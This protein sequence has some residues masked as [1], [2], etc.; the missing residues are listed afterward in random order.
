MIGLLYGEKNY[1]NMCQSEPST[2][3]NYMYILIQSSNSDKQKRQ[4]GLLSLKNR[5]TCSKSH[6]PYIMCSKCASSANASAQTLAPLAN[7]T[8]NNGVI[9]ICVV[10][11]RQHP[12]SWYDILAREAHSTRYSRPG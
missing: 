11:A 6:H 9:Q 12:R 2:Q 8:F 4:L 3:Y 5:Q 10:S 7:S 1:D